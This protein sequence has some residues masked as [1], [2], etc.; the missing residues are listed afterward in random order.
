MIYHKIVN[1]DS[2]QEGYMLV[3]N[4]QLVRLADLDGNTI[5]LPTYTLIEANVPPP[6]W[7]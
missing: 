4:N 6:T 2:G 5:E 1:E 7:A 3:E